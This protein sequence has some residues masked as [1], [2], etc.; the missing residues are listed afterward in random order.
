MKYKTHTVAGQT[1]IAP[2]VMSAMIDGW[3]VG[4]DCRTCPVNPPSG[5][6]CPNAFTEEEILK[7]MGNEIEIIHDEDSHEEEDSMEARIQKAVDAFNHILDDSAGFPKPTMAIRANIAPAPRPNLAAL[8]LYSEAQRLLGFID[9]ITQGPQM[10]NNAV[11][12][13]VE[14]LSEILDKWRDL[15]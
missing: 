8:K 9:G 3:C 2:Y 4:R 12:D 14:A 1:V 15:S 13:A 5:I 6:S 10:Q 7:R 11:S